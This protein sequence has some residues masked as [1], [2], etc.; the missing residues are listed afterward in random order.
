MDGLGQLIDKV[1]AD[2]LERRL[3]HVALADQDLKGFESNALESQG[4]LR[5]RRRSA[6]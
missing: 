6:R 1:E 3:R 2:G 5:R 4:E